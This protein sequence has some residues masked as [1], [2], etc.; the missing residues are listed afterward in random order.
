M[1]TIKLHALIRS[2]IH[3]TYRFSARYAVFHMVK[4]G[5]IVSCERESVLFQYERKLNSSHIISRKLITKFEVLNM[6]S[7]WHNLQITH[8]FM[9]FNQ[10]PPN[11]QTHTHIQ[12]TVSKSRSAGMWHRMYID[13]HGSTATFTFRKVRRKLN[14]TPG[15]RQCRGRDFN[16]TFLE[17]QT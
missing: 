10:I 17:R 13:I 1:Y 3:A 16:P 5:F 12:H 15:D 6:C 7:H 8:Y 9:C 11:S 4:F 14:F 2:A